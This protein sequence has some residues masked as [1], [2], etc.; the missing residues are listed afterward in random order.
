MNKIKEI[1]EKKAIDKK[2]VQRTAA[3]TSAI[4]ISI[5]S[6]AYASSNTYTTD[7]SNWIKAGAGDVVMAIVTV[8]AIE[9]LVRRKFTKLVGFV[10]LAGIVG[11]I[12]L[13]PNIVVNV[14][15]TVL[16]AAGMN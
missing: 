7:A 10:V 11:A 1:I 4:L 14:G 5:P 15:K 9:Q 13:N 12:V 8:F 3:I 16:N 6:M 2:I